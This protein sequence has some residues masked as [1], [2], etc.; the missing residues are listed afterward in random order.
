[1]FQ[2]FR[3]ENEYIFPFS[4]GSPLADPLFSV[5]RDVLNPRISIDKRTFEPNSFED[6]E[7]EED[8]EEQEM[9]TQK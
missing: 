2:K 5:K 1:M 4:Y 7:E 8:I 6:D 9:D 3:L